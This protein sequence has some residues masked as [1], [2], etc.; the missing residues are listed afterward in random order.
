MSRSIHD[1]LNK[2]YGIIKRGLASCTFKGIRPT[3]WASSNHATAADDHTSAASQK[4]PQI[5]RRDTPGDQS[6]AG[7]DVVPGETAVSAG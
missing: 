5:L 2:T 3:L 6:R 1:I 4:R 7:R